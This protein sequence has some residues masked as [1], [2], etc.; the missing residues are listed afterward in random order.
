VAV[1]AVVAGIATLVAGVIEL[2][3]EDDTAH[4]ARAIFLLIFGALVLP[5]G[6]GAFLVKTWAWIALMSWAVIGL[7]HQLLRHLFL[8]DPNYLA[9][10]ANTIIV[11]ALTSLDVQVA[12][13]IRPPRNVQLAKPTRNPLD[14]D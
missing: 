12:F 13:R 4:L 9:M 6:V 1:V 5:V 2:R 10:A 3:Q 14:L 11:F 7:T 8:D